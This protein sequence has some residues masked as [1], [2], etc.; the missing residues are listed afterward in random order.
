MW[1]R[2]SR[3]PIGNIVFVAIL[4]AVSYG[5]FGMIRDALILKEEDRE[6]AEKIEELVAKKEELEAQLAELKTAE[7]AERTAKERLNVKKPGEHVVVVVPSEEQSAAT[8]S[9]QLSVWKKIK[10]FFGVSE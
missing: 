8:T 2:I 3:S 7:A 1:S 10:K 4:A 9:A 5:V 6:T